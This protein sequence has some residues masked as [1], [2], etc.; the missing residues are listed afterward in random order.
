VT[1]EYEVHNFDS[2]AEPRFYEAVYSD[3]DALV[4]KVAIRQ[5]P[6]HTTGRKPIFKWSAH[7]F[8]W[9]PGQSEEDWTS[10]AYL[11]PGE[12]TVRDVIAIEASEET[13]LGAAQHDAQKLMDRA[14]PFANAL[15]KAMAASG[16]KRGRLKAAA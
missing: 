4:V 3:G 2:N 11:S 14:R 15:S 1:L 10:L 6:T 5:R 8:A 16:G 7:V 9:T 13:W 12:I